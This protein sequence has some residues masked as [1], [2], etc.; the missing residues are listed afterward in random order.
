MRVPA[1]KVNDKGARHDENQI[2]KIQ[3]AQRNGD[4]EIGEERKKEGSTF[5]RLI[6]QT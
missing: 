4:D 1:N 3:C 2:G 5:I 6:F